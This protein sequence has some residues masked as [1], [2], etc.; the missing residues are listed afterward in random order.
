MKETY[1]VEEVK[2]ILEAVCESL[3]EEKPWH[4]QEVEASEHEFLVSMKHNDKIKYRYGRAWL[5]D[6]FPSEERV[7]KG[8]IRIGTCLEEADGVI[9]VDEEP[10]A[11]TIQED[12][13]SLGS[14]LSVSYYISDEKIDDEEELQTRF[15]HHLEGGAKADYYINYSD[16]TGYLS[17]TQELVVGGHNLLWELRSRE[18]KFLYL[19]IKYT[20]YC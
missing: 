8:E 6:L 1:T 12:M 7:Y 17:T 13:K 3:Y 10:L 15:L 2:K 11:L 16:Y 5:D 18:R 14:S 4:V 20:R 9:F 19:K